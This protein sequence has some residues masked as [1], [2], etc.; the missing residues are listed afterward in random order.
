MAKTI[1][2]QEIKTDGIWMVIVG[3]IASDN[4]NDHEQAREIFDTKIKKERKEA[5]RLFVERFESKSHIIKQGEPF[6]SYRNI[7]ESD[8]Q[9]FKK[10][11]GIE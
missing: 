10:R 9:E 8:Y 7:L 11:E 5:L 4:P 3:L 2:E 6:L 1:I